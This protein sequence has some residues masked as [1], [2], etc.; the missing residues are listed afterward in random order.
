MSNKF[1]LTVMAAAASLFAAPAVM[2]STIT[3]DD[4]T[5]SQLVQ[6]VPG[7]GTTISSVVSDGMFGG[8]RY[9]EVLNSTGANAGTQLNAQNGTLT[10]NNSSRTSGIGY[11]VYD[12]TTDR[13]LA[14]DNSID[15]GVN[16]S[17]LNENIV[18]SGS[19]SE[20]FFSFDLSGFN[21]GTGGA[22]ALFSAFVWDRS[23]DRA[24]FAEIVGAEP[25]SP[26]LFLDE[27]VGDNI[28]WT[29]VGALAFTIDSRS[30]TSSLGDFGG[31]NFDGAVGPITISAVP[32][33]AS[34]LLMLGGLG[35]L[36]G[37]SIAARRRKNV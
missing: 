21:P 37:I 35:A 4:F 8:T 13:S 30:G 32:L 33:P 31:D 34:A 16:Y 3:V 5:T 6:D 20:T 24:E 7:T 10:F 23:G 15:V 36:A 11:I 17:G 28:D 9:M 14:N 2:A 25:I 12:G 22:T 1:S 19:L 27:F 26:N 29:Q 18:L